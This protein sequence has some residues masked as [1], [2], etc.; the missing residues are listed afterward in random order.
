MRS[1]FETPRLVLRELA[2]TDLDFVAAM[3]GHAEVM[4]FWPRPFTREEALGWIRRQQERYVRDGHGYWLALEKSTGQPVG[5]MGVVA[6]EVD[7]VTEPNL[8]Y[9]LHRPFWGRG[10]A[11]EAAAHCR[12]YVFRSL[13]RRRVVATIRP[14][15]LPSQKVALRIGLQAERLIAYA[16]FP[17]L[18]FAATRPERH[19]AAARIESST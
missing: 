5:Q 13:G 18:L 19:R 2:E 7:G 15:N 6:S 17:H 8:G 1:I 4:C 10:F 9:I 3:L 11:T 16:G 12:D 14:E